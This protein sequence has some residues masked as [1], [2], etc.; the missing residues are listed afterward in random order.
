MSRRTKRNWTN[1]LMLQLSHLA[2]M[3]AFIF[4]CTHILTGKLGLSA[5]L[6]ADREIRELNAELLVLQNEQE[7]LKARQATL[8]EHETDPDR[9][10][11][12]LRRNLGWLHPDE[13]ILNDLV[14]R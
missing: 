3:A 2:L 9:L 10:D 11:E 1:K 13:V 12:E 7:A 5:Y 14:G 8:S 4:F 6:D